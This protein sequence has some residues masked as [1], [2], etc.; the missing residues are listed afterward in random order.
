MISHLRNIRALDDAPANSGEKTAVCFE[1]QYTI[2]TQ[3]GT[4]ALDAEDL[5]RSELAIIATSMISIPWW[6]CT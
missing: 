4:F 6:S 1:P 2:L 5:L 3:E